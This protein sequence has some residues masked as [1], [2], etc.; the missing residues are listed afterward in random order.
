[1]KDH[2]IDWT[3]LLE[4]IENAIWYNHCYDYGNWYSKDYDL[5]GINELHVKVIKTN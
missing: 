3:I 5:C 4:V 2:V 1:M